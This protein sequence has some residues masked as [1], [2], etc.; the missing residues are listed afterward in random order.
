M[1]SCWMFSRILY[2]WKSEDDLIY[3]W[4][5]IFSIFLMFAWNL[6]SMILCS[7]SVWLF[8]MLWVGLVSYY[9][10]FRFMLVVYSYIWFYCGFY[11]DIS[12]L[13]SIALLL[14]FRV[15]FCAEENG[16][17]FFWSWFKGT[18]LILFFAF[19]WEFRLYFFSRESL[20][21]WVSSK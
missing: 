8:V 19:S 13:L 20:V 15:K 5:I 4:S 21:F 6:L 9:A 18:I 1:I 17:Y 10:L 7:N 3:V 14:V 2:S 12:I 16:V 11:L